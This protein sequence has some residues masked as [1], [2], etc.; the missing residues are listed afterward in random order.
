VTTLPFLME[1]WL[2]WQ[3]QLIVPPLTLTTGQPACVQIAE[4]PSNVP[5]FG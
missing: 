3:G 2:P 1:N 4:N 5:A